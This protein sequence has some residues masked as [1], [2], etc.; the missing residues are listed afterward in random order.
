MYHIYTKH[1]WIG[2]VKQVATMFYREKE[3]MYDDFYSAYWPTNVGPRT[4][5]VRFFMHT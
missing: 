4:E 1:E 3:E 5:P 2:D